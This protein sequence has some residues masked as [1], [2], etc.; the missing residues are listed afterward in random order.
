MSRLG[1]LVEKFLDFPDQ[2]GLAR[3]RAGAGW[4]LQGYS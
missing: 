4:E 1:H 2:V 3:R